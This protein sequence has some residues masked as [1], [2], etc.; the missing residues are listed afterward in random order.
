MFG[1]KTCLMKIS[2]V[3]YC[4]LFL[5]LGN[6]Y[7]EETEQSDDT[8]RIH[9]MEPIEVTG[10]RP[11]DVIAKP[12]SESS[13][14]EI[15]T[16]LVNE[17]EIER[18]GAKTIVDAL[19][20][21]P[22]AWIESRG[23]K[24]KQFFS[25]RGQKYPYPEYAIDGAWQR[26]F[27]ETPYFFS[28]TNI[29]RVEV[30]RSSAALL[31]GLGGLVGIVNIV[32]KAYKKPGTGAEMEYGSFDTYRFSLSHGATAGDLSYAFSGGTNHTA[33][34]EDKNAAESIS[35]FMGS[36]SWK[37]IESLRIKTN[38]FHLYGERKLRRAEP[39]AGKRFQQTTESFDP[40][41]TTLGNLQ[42]HFQPNEKLST[43]L[44]MH[45][46]DRDHTFIG[47]ETAPHEST[48]ERDYEWGA[49]IIQSLAVTDDNTLRFGALYNHWVAPNGKRFYVGRRSDLETVSAVAVDEQKFGSLKLDAGLRWAKTYINEYG[50]FNINGSGGKFRQVEPI[51]DQWEPSTF[52]GSAGAS[53]RLSERILLNLNVAAGQIQPRE[54]SL[55]VNM[56]EPGNE[57][58]IK[59][60]LGCRVIQE[61]VGRVSLTGF[62]TQQ[63]NAIVLSG[64]TKEYQGRIME[65][66][67]NRDQ[68]Q[69]GV[70]LD[71]QGAPILRV[72]E[73]FVNLTA[74][75]SRADSNGEMVKNEEKPELIA[76]GGIYAEKLGFDFS[77]L[78]KYVSSYE[79]TR[80]VAA[81]EGEKPTPQ[82]LGDFHSLNAS[83]GYTFGKK[84]NARIYFEIKNLMDEEYSTV[85]GYP[86]Y[87]RRYMVG[88][89]QTFN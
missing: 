38:L 18:Q 73:P 77:I 62:L 14:L 9:V 35:N 49:N 55:D 40:L 8:E 86:D 85:V 11:R 82:P 46:I 84:Q 48:D 44:V 4:L 25:V 29:E 47:D 21:V 72:I 65:L 30:I 20:Y 23:R 70:E 59:A 2:T 75:R 51:K 6:I 83:F 32:P 61:K 1:K 7:A 69:L 19:K 39:P 66:Y 79:S 50:A 53:Y 22:G 42:A 52:N 88:L 89:R 74:M 28:A 60:D 12:M 3:I 63:K 17:E 80:F 43:E 87:G 58:R 33:G 27:H 54:G 37:P 76:S 26:E 36:T 56:E 34:P 31:N 16:T 81:P 68:D 10:K 71:I 13:G 15:S 24:V 5:G 41:K 57:T 78:W 67:L 45:Y 64:Q